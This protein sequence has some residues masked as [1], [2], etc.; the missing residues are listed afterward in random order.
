MDCDVLV[1]GAGLSGVAAAVAAARRGASV[2]LLEQN[3]SPGGTPVVALH[4][5]ICGVS[6]YRKGLLK[7]LL[8]KVAPREKLVRRGR[9]FILP[10][11]TKEMVSG[12]KQVIR[13]EEGIKAL[14]K[15][16]VIALKVSKRC[17]SSVTAKDNRGRILIKPKVLIDASGEGV[18]I[19]LSGAGYRI[20]PLSQRQLSGFSFRVKKIKGG[21]ELLAWKVP[22][23]LTQGSCSGRLPGYL[24]FSLFSQ[25]GLK[26]EGL[27]RINLPAQ[28]KSSSNFTS[29]KAI[30]IHRYLKEALPE[31]RNSCIAGVSPSIS[32]REGLRLLGRYTLSKKDV[33][34][35]KRFTDTVAYG[36]WPVEFWHRRKGPQ[37]RY[38]REN[39]CYGIPLRSLQ[40]KTLDNLFAAG[41]CISATPEALAS[42]RVL[43]TCISLGEAAGIS[44][45]KLCA[46]F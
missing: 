43:G 16:R 33:F 13:G 6:R 27:I 14:Y 42:T 30:S 44:A 9:V 3:D 36:N 23:C 40:S 26:G 2:I 39:S 25:G 4:N 10:F 32:D 5:F 35:R 1:V 17:I 34:A 28:E 12:L 41:R 11:K 19:K 21:D 37:F 20:P 15:S 22:Y 7:E 46:S 18:L 29:K 24:K 45:S 31:F 8:N 38:F